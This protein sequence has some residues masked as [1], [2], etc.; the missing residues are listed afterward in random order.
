[1]DNHNAYFR[2]VGTDRERMEQYCL[3]VID[4]A[5]SGEDLAAAARVVVGA[6]MMGAQTQGFGDLLMRKV[7]ER[8]KAFMDSTNDTDAALKHAAGVGEAMSLLERLSS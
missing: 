4:K 2:R 5:M 7:M 8:V 1:M 6:Q 3:R